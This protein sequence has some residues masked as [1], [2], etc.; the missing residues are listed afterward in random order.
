ML[1]TVNQLQEDLLH[2]GLEGKAASNVQP[3]MQWN[4]DRTG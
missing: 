1:A 2:G 4:W 3:Y